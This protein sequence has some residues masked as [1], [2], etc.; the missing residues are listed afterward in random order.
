LLGKGD[1]EAVIYLKLTLRVTG[2]SRQNGSS[3]RPPSRRSVV[4]SR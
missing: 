1:Q 2:Q 3:K 4:D